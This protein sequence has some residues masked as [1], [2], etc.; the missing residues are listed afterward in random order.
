MYHRNTLIR[1]EPVPDDDPAAR[2]EL[3]VLLKMFDIAAHTDYMLFWM[4]EVKGIEELEVKCLPFHL[5]F[6]TTNPH[7]SR[8]FH[9]SMT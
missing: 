2:L 9:R 5:H 1:G 8:T 7:G 4:G 6:H 3:D